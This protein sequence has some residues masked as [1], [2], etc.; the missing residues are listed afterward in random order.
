M[1]LQKFTKARTNGS[2]VFHPLGPFARTSKRKPPTLANLWRA[3]SSLSWKECLRI[4]ETARIL[5]SLAH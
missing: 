3:S 1:D 2:M 5:Y 4:F